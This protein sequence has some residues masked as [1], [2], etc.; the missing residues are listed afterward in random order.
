MSLSKLGAKQL[1]AVSYKRPRED[2]A[3]DGGFGRTLE[4]KRA[5]SY[6]RQDEYRGNSLDRRT[7]GEKPRA[8]IKNKSVD[9]EAAD[10]L[11]VNKKADDAVEFYE[12]AQKTNSEELTSMADKAKQAEKVHEELE[13]SEPKDETTEI[14]GAVVEQKV[15]EETEEKMPDLLSELGATGLVELLGKVIETSVKNSSELAGVDSKS[16]SDVAA[17]AGLLELMN[18]DEKQLAALMEK[19]GLSAKDT[20]KEDY[21]SVLNALKNLMDN[22]EGLKSELVT[23]ELS[24]AAETVKDLL[25]KL[26]A[27]SVSASTKQQSSKKTESLEL[28]ER[29]QSEL[30]EILPENQ[31]QLKA[32]SPHLRA[33]ADKAGAQEKGTADSKAG[34]VEVKQVKQESAKTEFT[35]LQR[36]VDASPVKDVQLNQTQIRAQM[37]TSV[38]EQVKAAISKQSIKGEDH[39]EM[40]IKLKPEELG[41]VELKIEVHKD[42]VI[43]KFAVASQMVKEAIEANLSDLRSAL[44]DK[45]FENMSINV[46]LGQ[47]ESRGNEGSN[48]R[49]T[50]TSIAGIAAQDESGESVSRVYQRTLEAM[51]QE[52]TFEHLV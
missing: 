33:D 5:E 51:E 25:K 12:K 31:K 24:G 32:E 50:R 20:S 15:A 27:E 19:L 9:R 36:N 48:G 2:A 43:A 7:A 16:A 45:G 52:S 39:S 1:G 40:I 47:K 42:M 14:A 35:G 13:K 22:A 30:K 23:K 34:A 49:R 41:K 37:K 4:K 18:L 26:N 46:D 28:K 38:F 17:N 10:R 29:E 8:Q 6:P 44:K 21:K 3:V 11:P